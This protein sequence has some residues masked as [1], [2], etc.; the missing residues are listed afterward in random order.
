MTVSSRGSYPNRGNIN[1]VSSYPTHYIGGVQKGCIVGLYQFSCADEDRRLYRG[2]GCQVQ[3]GHGRV[4][5]PG[6]FGKE[7]RV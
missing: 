6:N 5:T 4:R 3:R 7:K 2:H 1:I